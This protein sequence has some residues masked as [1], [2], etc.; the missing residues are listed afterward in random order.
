MAQAE[1]AAERRTAAVRQ[2]QAAELRADRVRLAQQLGEERQAAARV[3]ATAAAAAEKKLMVERSRLAVHLMEQRAALANEVE[4]ARMNNE[5]EWELLKQ[6]TRMR[7][8][9]LEEEVRCASAL[10]SHRSSLLAPRSSLLS[11]KS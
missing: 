3:R 4:S 5:E 10:L 8:L 2:R 11:P 6:Q 1:L 7:E 9:E